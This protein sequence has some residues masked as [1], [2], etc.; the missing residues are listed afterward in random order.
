M[1]KSRIGVQMESWALDA[2]WPNYVN[3]R[4]GF[5]ERAKKAGL[6]IISKQIPGTGIQG[7]DLFQDYAFVNISAVHGVEGYIGS[8]IQTEILKSFKNDKSC[9]FVFVHAL[10]PFGMSWYHR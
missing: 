10:N 2:E 7:E 8:N 6:Q 9:N 4:Q 3:C 1:S 5:L